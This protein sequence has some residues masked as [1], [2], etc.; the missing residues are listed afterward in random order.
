MFGQV[1]VIGAGLAGVEVAWQLAQ[2]GISVDLIEQKPLTHSS[3]HKSND[4]AELVC[5]N[6]L[7]SKNP[8][9]AVG[10]LKE[11]MRRLGSVV[12]QAAAIAQV[13]AGD[14][15]AV[16]R[17]IFSKVISTTIR[18]HPQIKVITQKVTQIDELIKKPTVIA[19]G[20]LTDDALA[21]SITKLTGQNRLYFYDAIAPIITAES[22][23]YNIAFKAS[24]YDKGT[25][26]DYINCPFTQHEY[27]SF[28]DALLAAELFPLH[29]FEKPKYFQGC[30]PIEVVA[31]SGRD[32]LRYGAMKPVGL[33]DPRINKRPYAVVQ[34]RQED[35]DAQ[36][37]NL[38]G[39]QTKMLHKEQQRIFRQIPGLQ[40]AEFLRLGAIH[41]NTYID[42]P[43]LLDAK[44]RLS[45]LPL[46]R[47]AGQ[48][49][50][51]EG[52]VESAAHGLL[53]GLLLTQEHHGLATLA[54]PETC[55]L[56]GL[57]NHVL[58]KMRLPNHQFEPANV[59]WSMV[60]P[61]IMKV[62]KSQTKLL[63][64]CRA[65]NAFETWAQQS[66]L[67]LTEANP[68][69]TALCTEKNLKRGTII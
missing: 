20:P 27:D 25:G 9:N 67:Q 56:G 66:G 61:L 28:I 30:Q 24:R 18:N 42:S 49:T 69:I 21:D 46:L 6:S 63:R 10:L 65:L 48:I 58:G 17:S 16:D 60:P 35:R 12:M 36:A 22:I 5:S 32:A 54:P 33:R 45:H 62:H 8:L 47:F 50:G 55:A 41:R 37:Y 26:S 43:S 29:A 64:L 4:F 44:M 23:D 34:L 1:T 2:A 39:F 3:A 57:Y 14:A 13:Q 15:L 53:V 59:N 51:V 7:R 31:A 40:K 38:V 68:E 52:Y 19:T 11:E